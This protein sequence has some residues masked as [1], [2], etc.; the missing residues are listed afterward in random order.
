VNVTES[1]YV[2]QWQGVNIEQNRSQDSPGEHHVT[3]VRSYIKKF[4]L[5]CLSFQLE[6]YTSLIIPHPY[7]IGATKD[8]LCGVL[9][10]GFHTFCLTTIENNIW[11][12]GGI[13]L[14]RGV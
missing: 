7:L 3:S 8:K 6:K 11:A 4:L 14:A 5:S 13:R 10:K 9:T 1:H 12:L 2:P